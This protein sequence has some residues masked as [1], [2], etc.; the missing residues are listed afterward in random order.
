MQMDFP[1]HCKTQS[2][3]KSPRPL[4]RFQP[5]QLP[6]VFLALTCPTPAL[7]LVRIRATKSETKQAIDTWASQA[8]KFVVH[9]MIQT[10]K[11]EGWGKR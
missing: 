7:Y 4:L 10:S 9:V 6:Q 3:G 11:K 1:A 8:R 5:L 2:R